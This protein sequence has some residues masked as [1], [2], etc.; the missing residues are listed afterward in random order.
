MSFPVSNKMPIIMAFNRAC[1]I[2]LYVYRSGIDYMGTVSMCSC[3]LVLVEDIAY[4]V[5]SGG[6]STSKDVFISLG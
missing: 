4:I 6:G 2:P 1:N 5:E 3:E